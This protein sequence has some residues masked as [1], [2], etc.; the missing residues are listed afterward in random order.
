M[1]T[2][3]DSHHTKNDLADALAYA[4]GGRRQG[5]SYAMNTNFDAMLADAVAALPE[6]AVPANP[7]VQEWFIERR[8]LVYRCATLRKTAQRQ[9]ETANKMRRWEMFDVWKVSLII[10][11]QH[12]LAMRYSMARVEGAQKRKQRIEAKLQ[13]F[14]PL[15]S[16]VITRS[17]NTP[18]AL[19]VSLGSENEQLKAVLAAADFVDRLAECM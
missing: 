4:F 1:R 11:K 13:S 17:V 19:L 8:G 3:T 12:P 5:K 9:V 16:I 2:V 15:T 14:R 10:P 7:N 6:G 18:G